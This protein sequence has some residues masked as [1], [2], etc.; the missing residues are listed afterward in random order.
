MKEDRKTSRCFAALVGMVLVLSFVGA[1]TVPTSTADEGLDDI[2][3]YDPAADDPIMANPTVENLEQFVPEEFGD[4]AEYN[5]PVTPLPVMVTAPSDW[6]PKFPFPYD[7]TRGH[8]TDADINAERE[9]CQWFNTQYYELRR[10]IDKV[11]FDR[12]TPNGPGPIMGS[13]SDWDYSRGDLQQ[14]VDIVTTNIDQAVA[15]LGPRVNALTQ[16]TEHFG[17]QYFPIYE[18]ESFYRLWQHLAN[19]N[20]GIKSH[21]PDWFTGPSVQRAKRWGTRIER[22]H[23]CD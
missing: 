16:A 18:G 2:T 15:F 1:V 12:I 4:A 20:A 13:G 19:V 8:I 6:Q 21:Q 3:D 5:R 14:Q 10:Q 11:Q 23:V 17:D 7:Q 22:S 9:L